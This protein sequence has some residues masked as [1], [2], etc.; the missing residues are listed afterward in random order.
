M[1][2]VICDGETGRQ[3]FLGIFL[4]TQPKQVYL[5]LTKVTVKFN[6]ILSFVF[7]EM[8]FT[9]CAG[10]FIPLCI[11]ILT[12]SNR[13]DGLIQP[14]LTRIRDRLFTVIGCCRSELLYF[15]L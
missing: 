14:Q 12:D 1:T 10:A 2:M 9:L 11:L 13:S 15:D 8:C 4:S 5:M 6:F 3:N 7:N